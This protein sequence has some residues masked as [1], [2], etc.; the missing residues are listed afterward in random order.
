[1]LKVNFQDAGSR[2]IEQLHSFHD[3]LIVF[4]ISIRIT[5]LLA[6]FKLKSPLRQRS[7]IEAQDLESVWTLIPAIILLAI[8]LPSLRLLYLSDTC[9]VHDYTVKAIGHQWYWQYDYPY[10]P[11][12]D[13]YITND[14]YRFLEVDNRV[15]CPVDH[16]TQFLI[17]ASDVLHSWTLPTI[18]IKADA[19]PGR[20]NKLQLIPKR[21]GI[22]YGQCSEICGRNHSFM[23]ISI[24][25]PIFNQLN[26]LKV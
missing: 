7:Y 11:N 16:S 24:E 8:G 10:Y 23:P 4:V 14:F 2:F 17:S 20:V 18:G 9:S 19:V 13:S 5:T 21:P 1:M 25:A 12:F 15:Q 22:F 26:T 6:I 3:W